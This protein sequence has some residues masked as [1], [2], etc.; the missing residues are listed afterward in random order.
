MTDITDMVRYVRVAT[1]RHRGW[2]RQLGASRDGRVVAFALV[3]AAGRDLGQVLLADRPGLVVEPAVLRPDGLHLAPPSTVG[4]CPRSVVSP[5]LH[6]LEVLVAEDEPVT[7][8]WLQQILRG[9]GCSVLGPVSGVAEALAL[10]GSARP[11]VALLDADMRDG[12]AAPV[13]AWLARSAV[14]FVV[15][16]A[17]HP[18]GLEPALSGASLLAKPCSAGEVRQVICR[19][20][21]RRTCAASALPTVAAVG[22]RGPAGTTTLTFAHDKADEEADGGGDAAAGSERPPAPARA[23]SR[24]S[25]DLEFFVWAGLT[26]LVS[27]AFW[28][29][30]LY[31]LAV[32]LG[33]AG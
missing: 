23:E 16:T 28:G 18:A 6:G 10:L 15:L 2:A 4:C 30:V 29:A 22:S 1:A 21:P 24:R 7:A 17:D 12:T 27:A 32:L 9:F 31:G 11:D 13:A 3:D 33:L 8:L 25:D 5:D 20:F 19:A 26:T 14:P